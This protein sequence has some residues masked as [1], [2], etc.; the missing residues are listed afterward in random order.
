MSAAADT[1][2][3][4]GFAELIARGLMFANLVRI[5]SPALIARYNRALTRLGAPQ[6]GLEEFSVDI[7]GYSP[8]V[9]AEI[10]DADYLRPGGGD[11]HIVLLTTKQR[12]APLV[13]EEVSGERELIREFYDANEDCL[14]ALTA[15]DAVVGVIE[16]G[17]FGRG[18]AERIATGLVRLRLTADTTGRHV[19]K[20]AELGGLIH[21]FRTEPRAWADD[22]LVDEM[23]ARAAKVGD[24]ERRPMTLAVAEAEPKSFWIGHEGHSYY[25]VQG[26]G[27]RLFIDPKDVAGVPARISGPLAHLE[28]QHLTQSIVQRRDAD[29]AEVIRRMMDFVI[30]AGADRAGLS[31]GEGSR[32]DL[33]RLANRL[34]AKAVDTLHRLSQVL[35]HVEWG[36]DWPDLVPGSPAHVLTLRAVPGPGALMTN[37]L[38]AELCPDDVLRLFIWH[39]PLF[40]RLYEGWGPER[41][42]WV[43]R[44][45]ETTYRP[46]KARLRETTFGSA[47]KAAIETC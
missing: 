38:L 1:A 39:K 26:A 33:R 15:S 9:A 12:A 14:F 27:V 45:L 37:R 41:Q 5:D 46:Q 18:S 16:T 32:G 24:V 22:A 20:A 47:T 31:L 8:E 3:R 25:A 43:A 21:R 40:F 29:T 30:V 11:R 7:G 2:A 35:S 6:T 13:R 23:I 28:Q 34:D 42:A 44:W 4:P 10:G 19:E 17:I 36:S